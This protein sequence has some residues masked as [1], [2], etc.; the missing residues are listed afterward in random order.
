MKDDIQITLGEAWEDYVSRMARDRI[1][2]DHIT[3]Q[4]ISTMFH[5][6]INVISTLGLSGNR[7]IQPSNSPG[8]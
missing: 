1:Y 4:T 5:I 2:G 3:L 7:F 8:E 6:N